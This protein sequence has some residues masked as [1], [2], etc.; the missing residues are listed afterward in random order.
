MLGINLEVRKPLSFRASLLVS[1]TG[2]ASLIAIW[3]FLSYGGFIAPLF[4]PT[5]A[6]VFAA[7]YDLIRTR[8]LTVALAASFSRILTAMGLTVVVGIPV[9]VL[10][11]SFP[12][13]DSFLEPFAQPMRYVPITALL[14]LFILWFG[15]GTDM[16]VAF[17]FAGTVFYLIPLVRNAIRDVRSEY[18]ETALD[19]GL[20]PPEIIWKVLWPGALPQVW[21]GLVVCNAI[22]WTYV[23]L[24]EII[25]PESGLGYLISIAG[26]LQRTDQVFAGVIVIALVALVSDRLLTLIGR[27]YFFW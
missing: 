15:I 5:P 7:L 24:A 19:I 2:I 10:M 1:T 12:I 23:I 27:K 6:A 17:L 22:S 26:R 8:D 3:A 11:G 9:G 21:G 16:K 18:I 14:P 13:I 4:L 20:S 25:N